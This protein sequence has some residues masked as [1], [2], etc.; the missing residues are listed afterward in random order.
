MKRRIL[1]VDD[2]VPLTHMMKFNL[3]VTG[4]YEVRVVNHASDALAAVQSF[5]PEVI[6]LDYIMPH[7]NG[8]DIY[9]RLQG[10]PEFQHIP[11]I[12]VTALVSNQEKKTEAPSNENGPLMIAKPVRFDKLRQHI[13]DC[14][15]RGH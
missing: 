8:G 10:D 1:I 11:V 5:Q 12:M 6:L 14:L 4:A 3:E 7:L 13:D 2:D 9:Q 15:S